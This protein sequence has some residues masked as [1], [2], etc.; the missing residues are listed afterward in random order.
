MSGTYTRA[1]L[2][3]I[4]VELLESLNEHKSFIDGTGFDQFGMDYHVSKTE[5]GG[6][7]YSHCGFPV[8]HLTVKSMKRRTVAITVH[9][10]WFWKEVVNMDIDC[11]INAL[12]D[13]M[14][15][16]DHRI[17]KLD[18]KYLFTSTTTTFLEP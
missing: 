11:M 5:D 4:A 2:N 18:D 17:V 16:S 8:A 3:R 6:V 9:D 14:D 10:K 1:E 7:L 15:L 13:A 12:A